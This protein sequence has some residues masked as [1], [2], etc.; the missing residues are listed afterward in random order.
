MRTNLPV[1]VGVTPPALRTFDPFMSLRREIDRMFDDFRW[2]FGRF[3]P[4]L[5][6]TSLTSLTPTMDVTET[7]KEYE[8]T[9][10]L[11]GLEEKD[12]DVAVSDGVLTIRGEK[13]ID[14]EGEGKDFQ[15]VERSY[16]AFSRSLELPTGV[17][18]STIKATLEKGVLS[19]SIPKKAVD[20]KKIEV[21]GKEKEMKAAA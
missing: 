9:A 5:P 2:G 15:M 20:V 3:W 1:R 13:K 6:S 21:K 4:E 10:E 8:V 17:D 7:E 18:P 11:P 12:V 19:V 16:G 14:H